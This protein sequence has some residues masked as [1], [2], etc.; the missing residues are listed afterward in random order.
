M[1][2]D[3]QLVEL[4]LDPWPFTEWDWIGSRGHWDAKLFLCIWLDL[5]ILFVVV[6]RLFLGM[7]G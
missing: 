6:Q 7:D 5:L 3:H 2:L 1:P 4:G